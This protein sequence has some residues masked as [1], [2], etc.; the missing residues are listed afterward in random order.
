MKNLMNTVRVAI[1]DIKL[2]YLH[3][4]MNLTWNRT[5]RM[6]RKGL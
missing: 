2:M 5:M 3:F 6:L 4:V 1:I